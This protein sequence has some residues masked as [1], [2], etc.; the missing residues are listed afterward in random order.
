MTLGMIRD[1]DPLFKKEGQGIPLL[2]PGCIPRI[3]F[4]ATLQGLPPAA[5]ALILL[6][7]ATEGRDLAVVTR[8]DS[9]AES[10]TRDLRALAHLTS[11]LES[12][13][14]M[15]FPALD[16]D[17]YHG[18]AAHLGAVCARVRCLW[19]LLRG[20]VRIAVIPARALLLPLPPLRTLR[21]SF[22]EVREGG[23]LV[24]ADDPDWYRSA[25]YRRVDLT[26]EP[27]EYSRRGGILDIYPPIHESPVRIELEG[28]TVISLRHFDPI[29]QRS[30]GQTGE[31]VL[32]PARETIIGPAET[33]NLL[34]VLR[35]GAPD[36]PLAWLVATQGYFPGM[37]ACARLVYPAAGGILDLVGELSGSPLIVCDELDMTLQ[38]LDRE[39]EKLDQA[40]SESVERRELPPPDSL[41]TPSF[42]IESLLRKAPVRLR[43]LAIEEEEPEHRTIRFLAAGIP[44]YRGR[45]KELMAFLESE[46]KTRRITCVVMKSEGRTK[47]MR[48]LLAENDLDSREWITGSGTAEAGG[49]VLLATADIGGGFTLQ[50]AGITLI[51]EHE[52]FG[53]EIPHRRK[54]AIRTFTSDFRDLDPGGLVVH[55]DH[56]IGRY[57]GLSRIS[58]DGQDVDVMVLSYSGGD[59]LFLPVTRLDLV[60]KYSGV[61]GRAPDLDKL[62]GT[63]WVKAKKR[64]KKSMKDMAVELLNLYAARKTVEGHSFAHD[65][66]WQREFE[67][68]FPYELTIDQEI[69]LNEIKRDLESKTPMD[70]LLCGDVGFGKTEVALRAAF[71]AVMEGKQVAVLAPT[72]VLVFQHC[73]TFI[74]RFTSFPACIES[75]S[76]FKTPKEQKAV[77]A[78]LATGAVDVVVGTHRLLSKDIVFKDLGLLI[79]DEEQRFG[80]AHKERIKSLKKNVDVLTMTATPIP[81]TLQMSLMGVRDL[82]V[83]ETPPENRL[84][85][86]THLVPFKEAVIESAIRQ[87][88]ARDGQVYFV[89]NRVESVYNMA[90][91]LKKLVPEAEFGVAHGELPERE[92]EQVMLRFLR[93]KFPVLVSTT[94]IENGLDIPRVNTLIVN[95][96]DQFG[97]AQLY[98]LRGRIGRSDRQAYAYMLVPPERTM[99]EPARKRLKALQ[100]FSELGSGFRIAARDL[101]IRG[102]GN[103]L[104]PAQHGH[105]AAVGFELYCRMLEQA[106]HEM[107][108][109]QEDIPDFSASVNLG[110]DLKI[111]EAYIADEHHRLMFYK[112]IASARSRDHLDEI[113]EEMED[114]YGHM[115]RQGLN[116]L[117]IS[118]LRILAEKLR[119]QQ[120]DYRAGA[121]VVKF[122]ETSPVEPDRLLRFVSRQPEATFSPPAV[123]KIRG[124]RSESER[125]ALAREVLTALA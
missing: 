25:G 77:V 99:T 5:R 9:E 114:R 85:I 39:R 2:L 80:V 107:K 91:I 70:R 98:Q 35:E 122:G 112:R 12:R 66:Q 38:Q 61:G 53:D 81:R 33:E 74:E 29:D 59:K 24:H 32:S 3:E 78:G 20:S 83:I 106:V 67:E 57:E 63:G 93:G 58:G 109:G 76:R 11:A 52:I 22:I 56:G 69:T 43:E 87:E 23:R 36:G 7:L 125:V 75:L 92:L 104:G 124:D 120:C 31:V 37:E 6:H 72:T 1:P 88:L 45:L 103:L 119:V 26:T 42:E 102:A 64:I 121:L 4:P 15:T 30:T 41:V 79:V 68:G 18:L 96:A 82:S 21:P 28:D 116:L 16:A 19:G 90:A 118:G 117:E 48:N 113:R 46:V 13:T 40:A 84:A 101:E 51:A 73:N 27:G 97:L 10:L 95:R 100:E 115:P 111:P 60:Q 89:H 62:G 17:P 94:I 49:I 44:S 123:L 47:R 50:E 105:I 65:T 14:V 71:K 34:S 108:E 55:V 86:Q 8:N 54:A 110:V